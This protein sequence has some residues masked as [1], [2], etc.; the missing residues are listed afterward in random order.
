MSELFALE[1]TLRHLLAPKQ[2]RG[3][4]V[5]PESAG[6]TPFG[7][8]QLADAFRL[9]ARASAGNGRMLTSG[10]TRL[11]AYHS[12]ELYLKAYLKE[13][14]QDVEALRSYGH[15]LDAMLTAAKDAGLDPSP[16]IA[17]QLKKAADK[18]DYIRV[19]YMVTEERSDIS[20]EKVMRLA[21]TVR[22]CVRQALDYDE[23]GMPSNAKAQTKQA[24]HANA[25]LRKPPIPRLK[26]R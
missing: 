23:L 21:D 14:G 6:A 7:I 2:A 1:R 19:R 9:A 4:A 11:L 12:C 16:Q 5:T 17:A 10:P 18:N 13:R 26:T 15:D 3:S 8:F 25:R 22:D 24:N 20:A